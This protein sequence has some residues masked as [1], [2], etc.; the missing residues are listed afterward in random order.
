[1]YRASA[2]NPVS[3]HFGANPSITTVSASCSL[4]LLTH[5]FVAVAAAAT[6]HSFPSVYLL[7]QKIGTQDQAAGVIVCL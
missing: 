4:K 6:L 7:K 5:G 3:F 1:V 2:P